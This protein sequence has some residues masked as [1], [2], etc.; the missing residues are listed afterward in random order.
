M[1]SD[2]PEIIPPPL[3]LPPLP[4]PTILPTRKPS[5]HKTPSR[6]QPPKSQKQPLPATA[7]E[8]VIQQDLPHV[9]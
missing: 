7:S 9:T 4:N 1:N 2:D 3:N 5:S 8:E 6:K